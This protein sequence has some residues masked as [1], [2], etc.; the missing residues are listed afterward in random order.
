MTLI[1]RQSILKF[2]LTST[3]N[4]STMNNQYTIGMI[5]KIYFRSCTSVYDTFIRYFVTVRVY[6]SQETLIQGLKHCII[7]PIFPMF[8]QFCLTIKANKMII[9]AK[10]NGPSLCT[11][12]STPLTNTAN[13]TKRPLKKFRNV[14]QKK[15]V[16]RAAVVLNVSRGITP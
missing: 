2:G 15:N 10:R 12:C 3:M 8:Q 9:N 4:Q 1:I 7:M 11:T 13:S 6:N 16:V 14:S 5:R